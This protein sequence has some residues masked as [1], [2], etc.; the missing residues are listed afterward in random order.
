[1][2]PARSFLLVAVGGLLVLAAFQDQA[3]A[4]TSSLTEKINAY[5]GCINRLSERS[6]DSR[7]RYFEW[8]GKTGPT[9]K[10]RIV[11]GT[12]TIYAPADCAKGVDAANAAEPHDPALEAAVSAGRPLR[13]QVALV[14]PMSERGR[15]HPQ[16]RRGFAQTDPIALVGH[17]GSFLS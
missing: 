5:V 2:K 7:R 10:E 6:Y 1:M 11:Y 8:V 12:Y 17:P 14:G 16:H 15:M 4:Q 3:S 9:G 13:W